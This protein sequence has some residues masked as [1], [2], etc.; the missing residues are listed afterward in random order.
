MENTNKQIGKR[1]REIRNIANEGMKL[2]ARQFAH[3][4]DETTDKILNYENGRAAVSVQLLINLYHRGFNPVWI[5]TGEGSKFADNEPG[6]SLKN[7]LEAG[8]G[9]STAVATLSP[10]TDIEQLI[11]KAREYNV[12]AGNILKS[13]EKK[14][15]H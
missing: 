9:D 5:L 4:L 1:L 10:D 13:I 11:K 3:L 7:K 8:S 15:G 14:K 6:L 12:A 2:S